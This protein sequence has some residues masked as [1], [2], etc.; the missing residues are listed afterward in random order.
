EPATPLAFAL[1]HSVSRNVASLGGQNR[2][3]GRRSGR[4][5]AGGA[6]DTMCRG[7]R[8]RDASRMP[9]RSSAFP[10]PRLKTGLRARSGR[11]WR[12]RQTRSMA[13]APTTASSAAFR[14]SRNMAKRAVGAEE[15]L[16]SGGERRKDESVKAI[17]ARARVGA[18]EL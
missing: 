5:R 1:G 4:P 9:D 6:G 10:P 11:I 3:H 15:K 17:E 14:R 12:V 18:H 7:R 8:G 2:R 13:V 16:A